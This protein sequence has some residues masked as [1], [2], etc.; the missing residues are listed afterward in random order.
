MSLTSYH[1][2]EYLDILIFA[3]PKYFLGTPW[4]QICEY[5]G[6]KKL[7]F[8]PSTTLKAHRIRRL[9]Y[10]QHILLLEQ[11]SVGTDLLLSEDFD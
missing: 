7:P 2:L 5:L 4:A 3:A 1:F 9:D 11:S 10:W 6:E 8:S